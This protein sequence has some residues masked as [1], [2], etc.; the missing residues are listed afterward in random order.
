[1]KNLR[2][3]ANGEIQLA[4]ALNIQAKNDMVEAV[5]FSGDMFDCGSIPGFLEAT[6]YVAKK[7]KL[8]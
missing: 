6:Q 2:P 8:A 1:M 7:R 4:D 3:G 5:K